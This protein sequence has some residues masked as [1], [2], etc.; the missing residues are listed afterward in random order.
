MIM[1][2]IT[3]LVQFVTGWI[4]LSALVQRI[5]YLTVQ[6]ISSRI[7]VLLEDLLMYSATVSNY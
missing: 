4:I 3:A 7:P 5:Q 6:E 1:V 2:L